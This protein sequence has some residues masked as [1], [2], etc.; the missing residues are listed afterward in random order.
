MKEAKMSNINA[1]YIHCV[2]KMY[3][4]VYFVLAYCFFLVYYVV[5]MFTTT[6]SLVK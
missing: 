4:Y 3:P 5:C 1:C 2:K 6:I